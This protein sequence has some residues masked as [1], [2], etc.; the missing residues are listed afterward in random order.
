MQGKWVSGKGE[1]LRY[2][3][4]VIPPNSNKFS[5]RRRMCHVPWV[6]TNSPGKQQLE[7]STCLDQVV[8]LEMAANL[9]ASPHQ[10]NNFFVVMALFL[11]W[12]V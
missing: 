4:T 8:H 12:E 5:D 7:L 1:G 10:E 11:S 6:L 3:D 2:L 9:R